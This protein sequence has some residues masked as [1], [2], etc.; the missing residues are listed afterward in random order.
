MGPRRYRRGWSSSV[1]KA[2]NGCSSFNGA[3][4]LSSR[5][6]ELFFGSA[7]IRGKASMGPRRYRRGWSCPSR[8]GRSRYEWLQWGRDVIVADGE[9]TDDAAEEPEVASMGPRR[10]R[11]GWQSLTINGNNQLDSFNGAATLSSRM[12]LAPLSPRRAIRCFNGAATLSS[13]MG[14]PAT[15]LELVARRFNGA[16]TLSSRMAKTMTERVAAQNASMGPR[17]YRRGWSIS[18]GPVIRQDLLQWGRDVIVADGRRNRS[19]TSA[20]R[21]SM[22]P[23]R[24]RR[25]WGR[26]SSQIGAPASLLQWGRDVIVADGRAVS[27]FARSREASMGPR[28]YRRGWAP[29]RSLRPMITALQWGRDVIV[30]DGSLPTTSPN[31]FGSTALQWGRD[32]IVADGTRTCRLTSA[33]GSFNGAATLSS[34]MAPPIRSSQPER[35]ASMGPRR[36]RRGWLARDARWPDRVSASMGPRRYRR[37]WGR[38]C[39]SV[40]RDRQGFNGAATLSSRMGDCDLAITSLGC[41]SM[42]PRRYR[43]GWH[44]SS[45]WPG[46]R[47][48]SFNGAATLSSRMVTTPVPSLRPNEGLQ[49]GRDVIVADGTT[50]ASAGTN[51][52]MLQWGR[53]VIVADG[54][55]ARVL[56]RE[57]RHASMGPRRYRR[58]WTLTL[59]SVECAVRM[60]QWGRDVIVADGVPGE[61]LLELDRMLQWGRDVIVADGGRPRRLGEH[62]PR[63]FNGA[64]TLSSRMAKRSPIATPFSE[65]SFNGAATLSSRM[66]RSLVGLRYRGQG[67]NGAA[68]LSS[69][70]EPIREF[71]SASILSLQWGRDVI[72]ADGGHLDNPERMKIRGLQWGRDVIVADGW[73]RSVRALATRSFNGAATLSS[74]M[75]DHAAPVRLYADASMGPRRY[76][77]GWTIA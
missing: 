5:M 8:A 62:P 74:R 36:Y 14:N 44:G 11:R 52:S 17:R 15:D 73:R 34:R 38:R 23:R 10:Y 64:A 45:R 70:M 47:R 41:A 18:M 25:G 33:A 24:Y 56:V 9:R 42:G 22:G 55:Q 20:R 65:R 69:R 58:R 75:V 67:F 3:A 57:T 59:G 6:G 61:V 13:R 12:G 21:A 50:I 7:A 76:R 51:L 49:W 72:V 43:R 63:G 1:P 4:T 66:D 32:V 40:R 71:P 35:V 30:A 26:S 31:C 53:D 16:A 54:E 37:G 68:T 2:R 28:R 77:R 46:G 29:R 39:A 27:H 48:P 60:L 19:R